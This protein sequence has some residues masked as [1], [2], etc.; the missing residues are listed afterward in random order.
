MY[1]R[2]RNVRPPIYEFGGQEFEISSGAPFPISHQAFTRALRRAQISAANWSR[3]CR[4]F[5]RFA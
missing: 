2:M 5:G 1:W 3:I 4:V